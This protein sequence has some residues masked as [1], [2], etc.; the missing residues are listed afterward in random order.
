MSAFWCTVAQSGDCHQVLS[1]QAPVTPRPG[2]EE[3]AF[4]PARLVSPPAPLTERPPLA[5][6]QS[7]EAGLERQD[8]PRF[9]LTPAAEPIM[10]GF[11]SDSQL[12]VMTGWP[13]L[14]PSTGPIRTTAARS[15]R[16]IQVFSGHRSPRRQRWCCW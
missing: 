16:E 8:L 11:G 1:Y 9:L 7:R 5:P 13:A 10:D 15:G 6:V 2:L 12:E 3:T 4:S 14:P